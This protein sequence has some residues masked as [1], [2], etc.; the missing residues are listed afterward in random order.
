MAPRLHHPIAEIRTLAMK[1]TLLLLFILCAAAAFGQAGSISAQAQPI[2]MAEHPQHASIHA[3]A[4]EQPLVGAGS[5]AY[6]YEQ[7]ERPLWEFGPV[8]QPTP[9][10]DIARAVRKEKLTARKAEV[11]FEK[12][13]S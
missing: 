7:G 8:S 6:T 1:K 11:I 4:A 3:M 12:Q 13:G 9:L 5:N 2:M 10:G